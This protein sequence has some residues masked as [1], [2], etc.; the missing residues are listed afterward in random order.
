MPTK[1]DVKDDIVKREVGERVD[2]VCRIETSTVK[3][4]GEGTFE[5]TIT[6]SEK[7]R[8][9]ESIDTAGINTENWMK[10]PVVLYGHDYQ[11][12]PIGKGIS[13][14]AMKNKMTSKFQLAVNE[15]PFAKTVA[16]LITG[17][18]LS[19]VSI[20]GIVRQWN[21]DYTEIQVM[22]M[23]EFSVVPVP[24]NPSALITQRSLKD[25]TGK[26]MD[27]IGREYREFVAASIVD[28]AKAMPDNELQDTITS[29]ERLLAHLKDAHSELEKANQDGEIRKVKLFTLKKV[30]Q[31]VNS[32]SAKAIKLIKLQ[33]K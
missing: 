20:G 18:Y 23:V 8:H 13:L 11:S 26:S 16:D 7:D 31:D 29:L 10:N 19:A 30:A 12:L 21:E 14:K 33:E 9:M 15:Y 24:A 2:V 25:A 5:A 4:L 32:G 28:K 6:T 17:G 3:D 1:T 27:E 22:D